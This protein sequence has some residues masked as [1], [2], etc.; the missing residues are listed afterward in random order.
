MKKH[1]FA[2]PATAATEQ[3]YGEL[4]RPPV[5]MGNTPNPR[6]TKTCTKGVLGTSDTVASTSSNKLGTMAT[7]SNYP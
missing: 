2:R 6:S 4:R 3:R 5:F 1:G 7:P